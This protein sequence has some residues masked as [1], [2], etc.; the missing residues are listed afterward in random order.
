MHRRPVGAKN[1]GSPE[2]STML[3]HCIEVARRGR[4]WLIVTAAVLVSAAAGL[5][6]AWHQKPP[7]PSATPVPSASITSLLAAR[8]ASLR[9]A[10]YDDSGYGVM[11]LYV[12]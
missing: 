11:G 1:P 8:A 10:H 4:G 6:L 7:A 3:A 5:L 2:A 12:R 9:P